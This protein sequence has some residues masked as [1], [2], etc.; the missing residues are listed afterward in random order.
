VNRSAAHHKLVA[1]ALEWLAQNRYF[2]WPNPTGAVKS[3]GRFVRFG[4]KGSGDIFAVLEPNGRHAEFE[5]KTGGAVQGKDQKT[6]QKMV[7]SRGGI[8]FVFRSVEDLAE[9]LVL[10]GY[11]PR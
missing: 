3:E 6:H 4:K 11:P 2:A 10:A 5:A 1:E 7:T 8:Y 9:Q